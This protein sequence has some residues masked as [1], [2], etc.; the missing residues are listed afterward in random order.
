MFGLNQFNLKNLQ[1]P[2]THCFCNPV[3]NS[4]QNANNAK[5]SWK[6]AICLDDDNM[7]N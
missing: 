7:I 3:P 5:F 1:T 2:E 6:K 4:C